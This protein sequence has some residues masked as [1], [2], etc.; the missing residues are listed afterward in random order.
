MGL[1]DEGFCAIR[2]VNNPFARLRLLKVVLTDRRSTYSD[3]RPFVR[4]QDK[5][6][7]TR[8]RTMTGFQ[9]DTEC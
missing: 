2:D 9:N 7:F 6:S 8:E 4:Y 3:N 5:F 1:S